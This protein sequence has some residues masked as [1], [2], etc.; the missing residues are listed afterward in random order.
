MTGLTTEKAKK[1]LEENGYNTFAEEKKSKPLKI[2]INQFRDIM[3]M[4]LLAATVISVFLGE[5]YDSVTIILI[6]F[7]N[8]VLGFI[9]EYKTEK[10]LEAL[11]KIT[12]P[13][14]KV[15]RNGKLTVIKASE[16]VV[17][18]IAEVEAGDK[19]PADCVILNSTRLRA[20]ES[21]LTGES[22]PVSKHPGNAD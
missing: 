21:V 1:L 18:D 9:Q 7:L 16:I 11:K 2:F 10:T 8:A 12:S 15:Y 20:D 17:S 5:I 22:V 13:S 4:I 14:A 3:V 19:V 6:V